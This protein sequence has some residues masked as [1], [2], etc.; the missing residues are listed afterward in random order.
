MMASTHPKLL[1]VSQLCLQSFCSLIEKLIF[2]IW[3]QM[4]WI[5]GDG[6]DLHYVFPLEDPVT[7]IT[8]G[9]LA[10]HQRKLQGKM[11]FFFYLVCEVC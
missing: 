10:R 8:H 1:G 11:I 4:E 9:H 2:R 5:P 6:Q 3:R 7:F